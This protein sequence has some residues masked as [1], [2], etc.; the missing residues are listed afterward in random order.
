M[1]FGWQQSNKTVRSSF[2][3]VCM[4]VCVRVLPSHAGVGSCPS[5]SLCLWVA[6]LSVLFWP[7]SNSRSLSLSRRVCVCSR[8]CQVRLQG[9][10]THSLTHS[11]THWLTRSWWTSPRPAW[12]LRRSAPPGTPSHSR[13]PSPRPWLKQTGN[14]SLISVINHL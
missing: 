13:S 10:H 12:T 4:C 7:G 6:G 1:E 14:V 9:P 8:F 3:H 5:F 2:Q 11:L